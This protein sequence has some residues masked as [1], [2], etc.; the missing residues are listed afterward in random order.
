MSKS[1]L[2]ESCALVTRLIPTGAAERIR[3][4]VS[5]SAAG[6]EQLGSERSQEGQQILTLLRSERVKVG[7][8]LTSLGARAIVPRDRL[9]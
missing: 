1:G 5:G 2:P 7:D 6:Q 4:G 3:T 8:D 9:G